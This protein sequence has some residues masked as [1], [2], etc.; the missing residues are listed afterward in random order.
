[1]SNVR[2][3]IDKVKYDLANIINECD[4]LMNYK[5]NNKNITKEEII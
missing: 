2:L 4:K 3:I 1:M 5:I